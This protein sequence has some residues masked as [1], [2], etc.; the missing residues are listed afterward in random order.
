MGGAIVGT[1]LRSE[2]ARIQEDPGKF[3]GESNFSAIMYGLEEV[4]NYFRKIFN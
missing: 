1:P 3:T 2:E 4:E